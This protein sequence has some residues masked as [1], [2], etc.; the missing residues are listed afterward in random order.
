MSAEAKRKPGR[1]PKADG[2]DLRRVDVFMEPELRRAV[3]H[4]AA[5]ADLSMGAWVKVAI[6]EKLERDQQAHTR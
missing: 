6:R 3:L 4:A 2:G 1:P 5:D